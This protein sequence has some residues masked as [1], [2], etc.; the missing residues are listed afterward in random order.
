MACLEPPRGHRKN[1][2]LRSL[3]PRTCWAQRQII[4]RAGMLGEAEQRTE[5]GEKAERGWALRKCQQ[6]TNSESRCI[7]WKSKGCEELREIQAQKWNPS[8]T[9]L[10]E[11]ERRRGGRALHKQAWKDTLWFPHPGTSCYSPTKIKLIQTQVTEKASH[12]PQH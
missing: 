9:R 1:G 4:T 6:N 2:I 8:Y 7:T 3:V 5:S 11:A 12:L 10:W